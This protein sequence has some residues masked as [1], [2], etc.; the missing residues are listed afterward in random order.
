MAFDAM[1]PVNRLNAM[2][3][4]GRACISIVTFEEEHA[5]D[6]VK[7]ALMGRDPPMAIWSASRG[8]VDGLIEK[9]GEQQKTEHPAAALCL[10]ACRENPTSLVALDLAAHLEDARTLRAL[11]DLISRNRESGGRIVFIDSDDRLPSVIASMC[12]RFEVPLPDAEEIEAI[13]GRELR[14]EN[15]I[16]PI[17]VDIGK[18]DS[19]LI[20]NHLSGLT[21]EQI[22]QIIRDVV[23]ADRAL[24][25]SDLDEMLR[26]KRRL[27]HR[28]GVLEV[29]EAPASMDDI[30]GLAKLKAWLKARERAMSD[31]GVKFGLSAP[32]GILLLGVQGGGKSLAAKAIAAA[33]RRP[34]IR[35]DPGSLYDRYVGESERRLREALK[36]ADAMAPIVLWI[37]EIEKGFASA[38]SQSTDGGLSQRMFGALLAWMQERSRPVFLVATANDIDAL[39]PELLRKGR[40]DEIFFVDLPTEPIRRTI[41]EIHLRKRKRDPSKFDLG[42]LAAAAEGFSGAEIEQAI[43]SAMHEVFA[44]GRDID[45]ARVLE[46]VRGSPPL[47]AT[48]RERMEWLRDW[49]KGRCVP[50]D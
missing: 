35:L 19:R 4:A 48:A 18:D 46:A 11:R 15:K 32:R 33:F 47:S 23:A 40:F 45:T 38:A 7:S 14:R 44:A 39:P 43:V 6:I 2:L 9:D 17:R 8:L 29:V 42:A 25:A 31:E 5:L 28:A 22:R 12:W 27:L 24:T 20:L 36:Q 10:L 49:A 13:V 1:E 50:A 3:G 41:F 30:G 21:R 16:S 34:L 26:E 37:D